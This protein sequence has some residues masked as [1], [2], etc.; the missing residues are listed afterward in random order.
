MRCIWINNNLDMI[1]I[2]FDRLMN[3]IYKN[4]DQKILKTEDEK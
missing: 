2:F 1:N 4:E 3:F